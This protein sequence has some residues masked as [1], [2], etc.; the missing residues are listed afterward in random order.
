MDMLIL[1]KKNKEFLTLNFKVRVNF[2]FW[3]ENE[4]LVP[5]KINDSRVPL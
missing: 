1:K 5:V 3:L 4:S 2:L